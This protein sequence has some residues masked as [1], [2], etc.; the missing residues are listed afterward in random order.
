M[1]AHGAALGGDPRNFGFVPRECYVKE[2]TPAAAIEAFLVHL[3]TERRASGHTVSAYAGDLAGLRDFLAER[4]GGEPQ[5]VRSIDVYA[6]RGWLGLLARTLAPT[7]IAR[8]VAAVRSWMRWLRKRGVLEASPAE[9]LSTPKAR[10]ALPTVL[11]VDLAKEVV[12]LPDGSTL[13]LRD[14]AILE[15]LYGCGLRVSE[16]TGLDLSRV[17]LDGA[18]LR[19][20]GKGD[21]ERLVPMGR[22]C[23]AALRAYLAAR[24]TLAHPKTGAIDPNALVLTRRGTRITRYEVYKLVSRSGQLGAGRADLHPHALRH[25]CATHMLDGGADLRA[26]QEMLGHASLSTTQKYAH[27]SMEH[28]LKVYD[29]AHPLARAPRKTSSA[30]PRKDPE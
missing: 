9:Q 11:S 22:P 23:V 14:R 26:I 18:T 3:A 28:L 7:S 19:V 15:V 24:G 13:G 2:V 20:I 16:L 5:D 30:G 10:P 27:V 6:L 25:T 1:D 8:K 4:A 29:G 17:D 21:K 12:E